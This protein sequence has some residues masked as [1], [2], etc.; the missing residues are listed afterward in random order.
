MHFRRQLWA[1]LEFLLRI[2]YLKHSLTGPRVEPGD[3]VEGW[4]DY[5]TKEQCGDL[6]RARGDFQAVALLRQFWHC[7]RDFGR[8]GGL[9]G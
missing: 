4:T 5:S 3:D 8:L 1:A 6:S 2:K 9:R 7:P